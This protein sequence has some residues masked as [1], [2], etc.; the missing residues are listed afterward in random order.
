[1]KFQLTRP[2]LRPL[3]G[4]FFAAIALL[5]AA[6]NGQSTYQSVILADNPLAYYA[7][8][9]GVDGTSTAPDLSGNANDGVAANITPTLGPT[10]FVTNAANF[11]GSS[12]IDLSQQSNAGLLNFTGPIALEAWAQP[13]SSSLFGDILA[14]GYDGSD[15]NDEITIRVNGP[16]GGNYYGSSGS[17]GVTGGIQTTKWTYIVLSSDGTNTTLYENG[18]AVAHTS[19]TTGS[20][21]FSDDWVIGDGSAD[22]GGR[23]F[24]GNISEVALY[25]HGLSALQV[26]N[27][28]FTAVLNT[29]ATNSVPLL[30][31]VPQSA[32]TILGASTTFSVSSVSAYPTTNQWYLNGNQLQGQ[33]NTTLVVNNISALSTGSYKVVVGNQIGTTNAIA[34]LSLVTPSTIVWSSSG[35]NNGVWDLDTTA[36]WTN[37]ANNTATVFTNDDEVVFNDAPG[38]PTSVSINSAV[39]PSVITVN[40]SANNYTFSSG[41]SGDTIIGPGSLIKEG[42]SLL[43]IYAPP[44][45]SGSVIIGGGAIDA[46]TN[47]F[48]DV[49]S[50]TISNGATLDVGGSSLNNNKPIT[51]SGQGLNGEGAI[52]NTDG[53]YP[54]ETVNITLA[55]DTKFGGSARWDM[56]SG[57]EINGAYN[58]IVDWSGGAGYGQWNSVSID[59]VTGIAVTN[60][61][62]LGMTGMDNSFQN[63]ATVV[64]ISSGS[65]VSFYSGG[66]NGSFHV[67]GGGLVNLW[68]APSA[69]TGTSVVLE[70]GAAWESFY[71]NSGVEPVNSAITL[72]GVAHIVVGDHFMLYTNLI[73]GPGGFVA[74]Q[75]NHG[76]IFSQA[77]T[78]TG[79]TI[80]GGPEILLTNEGSISDSSLIFF[81]G[82]NPTAVHID[83]TGR[84][85]QTL[86][87]A[88]GQTLEGVG[89]INGSLIVSAGATIAPAGT[90]T[91][92]GITTGT[93]TVGTLE[94]SDDITLSGTTIL[95]LDGASNDVVLADNAI[96]YGGTL[97]LLNISGTP[98]TAGNTFQIFSAAT[99]GGSFAS[100]TPV[101]P[102]AGLAWDTNQLSQGLIGVVTST[103]PAAP[104]I[105]SVQYSS[106]SLEFSGS[107]GPASGTYY[108]LVATNLTSPN[109]VPLSTN[110]YDASGN[111]NVTITPA[112]GAPQQY[113]KLEQ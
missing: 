67:F 15:N 37:V 66:F 32:A 34:V 75:Y 40:S 1:M 102:G 16:Y 106:G 13:N 60:G 27:H 35:G 59:G 94:A 84:N 111:F 38:A 91:T 31:S 5:G 61:S 44:G 54:T 47:V 8:N 64:S 79:P 49:S 7:L 80:L 81:G 21:Q 3:S 50:I 68:G 87:L 11:N 107:G 24:G 22:G 71:N 78:Y 88:S 2:S 45:L 89:A 73:S 82:A 28:Y 9:P 14:K 86:T 46:A 99:Y 97:Q 101:T 58:L 96:T 104:T 48:S 41:G 56:G 12:A 23:F 108:V 100:I 105:S 33:T 51:V 4:L 70:D 52:Y 36:N 42:S 39:Q 10:E 76:M 103:A 85:D 30:T 95:K 72:N 65:T 112:V 26:L 110:S 20:I 69:F 93:N 74:D 19:D 17:Q 90:N 57:A 43:T 113:F 109:W 18:V 25:D 63:P 92:I 6:A 83:A 29:P 77:E 62:S 98:L 53:D 55:G